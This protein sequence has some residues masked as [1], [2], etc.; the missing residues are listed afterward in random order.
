M[1]PFVAG[2]EA[3]VGEAYTSDVGLWF[4][5]LGCLSCTQCRSGR[6][7]LRQRQW[8]EGQG[9]KLLAEMSWQSSRAQFELT[10]G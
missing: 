5:R 1:T 4:S 6:G 2:A 7:G 3:N 9:L 8:P 10:Q